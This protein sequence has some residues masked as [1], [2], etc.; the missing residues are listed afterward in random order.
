MDSEHTH[1]HTQYHY[2]LDDKVVAAFSL[3][4]SAVYS[5]LFDDDDDDDN[6][7]PMYFFNY[8][9]Y[10]GVCSKFYFYK[11]ICAPLR[12]EIHLF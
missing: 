11:Y 12:H 6:V 10:D 5:I 8:Y 3:T 1:T 9:Y 2:I 4:L 7:Y